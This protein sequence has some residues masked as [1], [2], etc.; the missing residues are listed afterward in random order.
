MKRRLKRAVIITGVSMFGMAIATAAPAAA[1]RPAVQACVGSTFS[2]GAHNA[3][4]IIP[5]GQVVKDFA[6][7]PN[8]EHPGL[9][10]GIQLLQAGLVPDDVVDNSCNN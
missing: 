10:D 2:T 5:Q 7:D 8:T 9:G 1:A 4:G 6:Q 3:H